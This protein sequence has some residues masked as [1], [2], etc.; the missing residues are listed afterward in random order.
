[1]YKSDRSLQP[2][3][4]SSSELLPHDRSSHEEAAL[5]HD[6]S[7]ILG[8]MNNQDDCPP[9]PLAS[10]SA[11]PGGGHVL[12]GDH[13]SGGGQVFTR[14]S[15]SDSGCACDRARFRAFVSKPIAQHRGIS[16]DSR[17]PPSEMVFTDDDDDAHAN[18]LSARTVKDYT[19]AAHEGSPVYGVR[20]AHL[21][22]ASSDHTRQGQDAEIDPDAS[23]DNRLGGVPRLHHAA[24]HATSGNGS[25]CSCGLLTFAK[26][27][28]PT[29]SPHELTAFP[30]PPAPRTGTLSAFR[31][32]T[33]QTA[34]YEALEG[35]R[36]QPCSWEVRA[37]DEDLRGAPDIA[38]AQTMAGAPGAQQRFI[39]GAA[40]RGYCGSKRRWL[41]T[42]AA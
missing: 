13:V 42:A 25:T 6:Q 23:S 22:V 19:D 37:F 7:G 2:D 3:S 33:R 39:V 40:E 5:S 14:T 30:S 15:Q 8:T 27:L 21:F 38:S 41:G 36:S 1:M 34:A 16:D 29:G 31:K 32:A 24:A 12:V 9:H 17:A 10:G 20:I 26:V 28:E 11:V 18:E 35:T 4:S